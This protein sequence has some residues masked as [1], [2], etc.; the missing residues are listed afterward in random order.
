MKR[1]QIKRRLDIA[2]E[3]FRVN[4]NYLLINDVNERSITHRLAIYIENV[5]G[6]HFEV[7][8]EYNK[9]C[10]HPSERKTM[11]VLYSELLR[12]RD[13]DRIRQ[14]NFDDNEMV[15]RYVYPDIVIHK[16]G[17]NTKNLLI[18]EVKKSSSQENSD[19]DKLKL[20]AYTNQTSMNGLHYKYGVFINFF[21]KQ[22]KYKSPQIIFFEN[23]KEV[24]NF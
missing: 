6:K 11:D 9:N 19:Y 10:G 12:Y 13:C 16:R 18:I 22:E 23:G 24:T 2:I 21:V 5:F 14:M 15:E 4:D 1:Y 8:C 20:K 3:T 7:D 17:E